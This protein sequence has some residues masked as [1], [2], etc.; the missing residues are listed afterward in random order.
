VPPRPGPAVSPPL[1]ARSGRPARVALVHDWFASYYGSERVVAEMLRCFP[2]AELFALVDVLPEG[3]R[4]F[5]GQRP[6]TT[7]FIQRLPCARRHFRLYLPLMPLAIEQLDMGAFDL[8]LSSSHAFAKG[9]LTGPRQLHVSYVHAPIRYA[10]EYQHQYLAESRLGRGPLGFLARRQLH[11]L[12]LWDHRTGNGVDRFLANSRFIA[13]RIHKIYR[14][15]ATVVHPPVEVASFTPSRGK[16]DHYLAVSRFVPYKRT[17]LVIEAFRAL[18]DRRL[19]VVGE[20][21]GYRR[22]AATAPANVT[23]LGFQPAERLRLLMARARALVFAAEEDFGITLVEAQ[24]AGTPV[25]AYRAGGAVESI[26]GLEDEAPTGVL[27][28]DQDPTSIID[29]IHRLERHGGAITA[30]ACRANALRFRP[31]AFREAFLR[32]VTDAWAAHLASS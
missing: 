20:G 12:R 11:R 9:V 14:R 28:D 10:W 27:F 26:R 3:E 18:P 29:A 16:D 2:Q 13:S 32:E 1:Q 15:E 8:V 6:V 19:V 25:I 17:E 22:A 23:L 31:E 7:S 5:L 30:E 21:P 4:G 24:A